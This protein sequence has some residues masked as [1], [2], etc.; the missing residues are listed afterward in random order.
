MLHDSDFKLDPSVLQCL[1]KSTIVINECPICAQWFMSNDI[2][3]AS[4]DHT[5][6]VYC[7]AYYVGFHQY[8]KVVNYKE[9]FQP[10]WLQ[11]ISVRPL[12]EDALTSLRAQSPMHLSWLQRLKEEAYLSSE[13]LLETKP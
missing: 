6:H 13:F 10:T 7:I 3:V 4:C 12:I 8:C 1:S 5:Y 9:E 11:F 2:I